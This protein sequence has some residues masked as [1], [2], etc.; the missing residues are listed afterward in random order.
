MKKMIICILLFVA[1]LALGTIIFSQNKNNNQEIHC[2]DDGG[3]IAPGA[4]SSISFR[5]R[6]GELGAYC[7]VFFESGKVTIERCDGNGCKAKKETHSVPLEE[8]TKI[9]DIIADAE[10][11]QLKGDLPQNEMMA[12]DGE[13]AS[14]EIKFS[15]ETKV[16]FDSTLD[17]P[18][19]CFEA[20]YKV[21]EI[22]K[23]GSKS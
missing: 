7:N 9:Q 20:V 2:Y 3:M 16:S 4:I 5:Q 23:R 18:V 11:R 15:D 22:L 17:V 10:I 13:I 14:I 8:V 21:V 12:L 1:A 19:E 6:G